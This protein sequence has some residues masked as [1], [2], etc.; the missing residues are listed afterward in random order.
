[1]KIMFYSTKPYD[2]YWF[3]PMAK[4][5]GFEI[6]FVEMRCDEETVSL[7]K[8]YDAICIFVNDYVNAA[9]IDRLHEMRIK[10]IL[11]RCA[12][13]NNVDLKAAEG[14]IHVLR[15]PSYSPEAVAEFA[16]ALLLTVNRYTHKAYT[17]TRDF[18]MNIN[19][20]M[21][22]DLYRKTAGV[23]GTG[24]IGQAM[25]RILKG[26]Q[27]EIL[28][29]DPYPNP[30]LDVNYVSLEELVKRSDVISL[31]CPLTDD[32]KHLVNEKTISLMKKGVYLVNTSRGALIDT[33][34]LIDGLLEKKFA[35][36]GLDVYEEEEGVFYE[37]RSNEIMQDE[38]LVRLT[39]FPNVIITS[40][41]GFFTK[42]ATQS[43]TQVTLENAYAL[44][45]GKP[46]VNEVLPE[47]G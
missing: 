19:G 15:V 23:V 45:T 25:I 36:V 22:T 20:F 28:A 3:E 35:G 31:H 14:R 12:G 41:M 10:G 18:N 46:L 33:E 8:G 44:E 39:A 47:R 13:F 40:H 6:H 42:E 11:L 7:A 30:S 5:Y 38:N 43:I 9:M 32:T 16:M 37:D 1:M 26:F 24:K 4:D 17:R 2:R 34:A 21:G 29:F 27:M